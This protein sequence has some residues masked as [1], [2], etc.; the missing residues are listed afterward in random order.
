MRRRLIRLAPFVVLFQGGCLAAIERNLD[1]VLAPNALDNAMRL[2]N[3]V[4]LP[5]ASLLARLW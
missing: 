3:S 5:L 4:F 2:P 1:L